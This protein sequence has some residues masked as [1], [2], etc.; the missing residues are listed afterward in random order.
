VQ[1]GA[2][3]HVRGTK[4]EPPRAPRVAKG[5]MSTE[6]SAKTGPN[7]AKREA[8]VRLAASARQTFLVPPEQDTLTSSL[9]EAIGRLSQ[10]FRG[11]GD[12]LRANISGLVSTVSM[13]FTL[14]R[15]S[16]T[17]RHWQRIYSAERI[18]S[19]SINAAPDETAEELELR[20]E[21]EAVTRARSKMDKFVHS[22][23]GKDAFIWD[24]LRF[25][26]N[27]LS[28]QSV[29][30]AA[31][32]LILQGAVLCWGAFEVLARDC[33]IVHLNA[34][35]DRA[36]ILL[37]DPAAKRRFEMSKVS[38]ET[39]AFHNFNLSEQMGTLL[40][41]QQDLSDVYSV[42]SVYQALFPGDAKLSEALNDPDLRLLSLRRNLIVHQCGVVD[43]IYASATSC[44]QRV[45]ERLAISP[46]NLEDHL[47]TT[48]RVATCIL[49][50]VSGAT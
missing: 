32:E 10:P 9:S 14:A 41:Q 39:L 6:V 24:T 47:G 15:R 23:V 18:R 19:L 8:M 43:G 29:V 20:R 26:E 27:L 30:R 44:S 2:P 46:D 3:G 21:G 5:R 33:F 7:S 38:L 13:P 48:L 11:I 34:K 25:L 28:D 12:A 35:P 50:A 45:S 31:S 42:K 17:D 37:G 40:A 4:A 22:P 16:T 1:G 36:L 49:D